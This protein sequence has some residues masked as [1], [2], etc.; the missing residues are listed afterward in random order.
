MTK[1]AFAVGAAIFV[2]SGAGLVSVPGWILAISVGGMGAA[3]L[4]ARRRADAGE[5]SC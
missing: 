2:L 3:I 1:I 5:V 4:G